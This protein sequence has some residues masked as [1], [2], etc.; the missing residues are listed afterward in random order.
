M[1]RIHL[2]LACLII[3]ASAS[4]GAE[5]IL[6]HVDSFDDVRRERPDGSQAPPPSESLRAGLRDESSQKRD[7]TDDLL[8]IPAYF[9]DPVHGDTTE[10]SAWNVSDT[11]I[12][13]A[14]Q[15]F[16]AD[17]GDGAIVTSTL[18][19]APGHVVTV[20]AATVEDLIP[21]PDGTFFGF[22]RV[23]NTGQTTQTLVGDFLQLNM[24]EKFGHGER[25]VTLND[26]CAVAQ[27][28]FHQGHRGE[29]T[30]LKLLIDTPQG[31]DPDIDP[32]TV[33]L[34]VYDTV[35]QLHEIVHIYTGDNA[36]WLPTVAELTT[37]PAG[38]LVLDFNFTNGYVLA[39]YLN[40]GFVSVAMNGVCT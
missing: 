10:F 16:L 22:A 15:F 40:S 39:E 26:L 30:S 19:L 35:G 31:P 7:D 34:S 20:N 6:R 12:P 32:P 3:L 24:V 8:F 38:V 1:T 21:Q 27:V 4:A 37:V 14:I 29:S 28:R 11:E 13:L 9:V 23:A 25:M 2:I 5:V 17:I 18:D 36:V 33:I